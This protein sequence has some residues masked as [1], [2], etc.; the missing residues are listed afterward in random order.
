MAGKRSIRGEGRNRLARAAAECY[1]ADGRSGM[2]VERVCE[3]A[4]ASVGTV[5]HH[6]PGGLRGLEDALYL[7]TVAAYQDG[8]LAELL[9]HRSAKAG[10]R[11]TVLFHIEWMASNLPLAHFL[12]FFSASWLERDSVAQL[13]R[14]NARF[15]RG[16]EAWR[17]PHV[18]AGRIRRL[19]SGLYGPIVLGPAQQLG[20]QIIAHESAASAISAIRRAGPALADAAWLA[21]KG[22]EV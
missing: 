20:G 12:L 19:P 10:V 6:F 4:G 7:D 15:A 9:T 17:A 2:T 1:H 5:Y 3:R 18:A 13:E 8:L 22:D 14:M 11:A 21:V 16:A